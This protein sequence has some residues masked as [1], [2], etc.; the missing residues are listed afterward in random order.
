MNKMEN[1]TQ[2]QYFEFSNILIEIFISYTSNK[3]SRP[4]ISITPASYNFTTTSIYALK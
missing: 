2:S 1:I 3:N 4:I